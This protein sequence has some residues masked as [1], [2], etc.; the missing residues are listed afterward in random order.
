MN[1]RAVGRDA[2]GDVKMKNG[3][4]WKGKPESKTEKIDEKNHLYKI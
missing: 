2:S 4:E 1:G 3:G